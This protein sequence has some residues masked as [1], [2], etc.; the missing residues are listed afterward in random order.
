MA[1]YS[2]KRK[3]KPRINTIGDLKTF[4]QGTTPTTV[5]TPVGEDEVDGIRPLK[6]FSYDSNTYGLL[7]LAGSMSIA[8]TRKIK[9]ATSLK[10]GFN[11]S[12]TRQGT[13]L[14][15]GGAGQWD[16]KIGSADIVHDG[17]QWIL[18]YDTFDTGVVGI[19]TGTDLLNLT[20]HVSNPLIDN[21]AS[22]GAFNRYLRH[23]NLNIIG[24]TLYCHYEGRKDFVQPIIN[25][26][27]GYATAPLSDITNWTIHSDILVNSKDINYS[28]GANGALINAN[29]ISVDGYY[30]IWWMGYVPSQSGFAYELGGTSYAYSTD[31]VNW[32]IVGDEHYHIKTTL[33]G[34]NTSNDYYAT[35][36]EV[37]PVYHN[38]VMSI[39][40][41]DI[42]S[43][44]I[45]N[46][47][48]NGSPFV[49][50][51]PDFEMSDNFNDGIVDTNKWTVGTGNGI[52]VSETGGKLQ[53]VCDGIGSEASEPVILESKTTLNN[54]DVGSIVCC[55]NMESEVTGVGDLYSFELS[56][57]DRNYGVRF[58]RSSVV[59]K[60]TVKRIEAGVETFSQ[61]INYF[62]DRYFKIVIWGR[63]NVYIF[64]NSGLYFQNLFNWEDIN[65]ITNISWSFKVIA[66]NSSGQT[67]K[68]NDFAIGVYDNGKL[69]TFQ[70]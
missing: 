28:T 48:L 21:S 12:W 9:L 66:N 19:A 54:D 56:S 31:L 68:M 60:I 3:V 24:D 44:N 42:T 14:E 18:A 67:L 49:N 69:S 6:F 32:N 55:F 25:S 63:T 35:V 8:Q 17:S 30:Y 40:M 39:Y 34:Y 2:Q 38:G 1:L 41:W 23:V 10:S 27:I 22:T 13:V 57:L 65:S 59:D 26:N 37:T 70:T 36:Q 16:Y 11:H 45:A 46:I 64:M 50:T 20:K 43:P 4:N 61:D 29:I 7:Y 52:T 53:I 51:F 33:F 62:G 5:F 15:G 47:E 58:E